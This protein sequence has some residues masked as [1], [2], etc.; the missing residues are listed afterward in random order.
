M[1]MHAQGSLSCR[2]Y[3]LVENMLACIRMILIN[4]ISEPSKMRFPVQESL[5]CTTYFRIENYF[6]CLRDLKISFISEPPLDGNA[7]ARVLLIF[8]I[9]PAIFA[10]LKCR[11]LH[12]DDLDVFDFRPSRDEI[13]CT[14]EMCQS[15]SCL[16]YFLSINIVLCISKNLTIKYQKYQ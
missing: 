4:F 3:F 12:K 14:S 16:R 2:L 5:S 13:A 10:Y 7:C 1:G 11:P 8:F 15:L 9:L 6:A